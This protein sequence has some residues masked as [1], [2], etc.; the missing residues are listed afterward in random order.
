[1][2]LFGGRNSEFL[3]LSV[4]VRQTIRCW[5]L[6]DALSELLLFNNYS[7]VRVFDWRAGDCYPLARHL[8]GK[9]FT[10]SNPKG[11]ISICN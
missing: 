9:N 10:V 6:G 1:M 8:L 5:R 7:A 4:S 3:L 2:T 11:I